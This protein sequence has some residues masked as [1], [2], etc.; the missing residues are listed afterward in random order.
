MPDQQKRGN[1]AAPTPFPGGIAIVGMGRWGHSLHAALTA[2]GIPPLELVVRT[3]KKQAPKAVSFRKARFDAQ[4]LW[5]CVPDAAIA[6]VAADLSE[7]LPLKEKIVVHSSGVY[8]SEILRA[9]KQAGARVASVHPLMTF[10]TLTPVPLVNV[11]FAIESEKSIAAR[12]QKLVTILAGRP[13][14][15]SGAGKPLYHAAA[16][17]ASPLLVGLATAAR[18]MATQAGLS[19]EDSDTLLQPIMLATI[20]NFFS[21]GGPASFSGPFARGDVATVSLHLAALKE[22]PSLQQV[23]QALANFALETLPVKNKQEL[24]HQLGR[25]PILGNESE[26]T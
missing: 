18:A 23:Y 8:S 16:V 2:A 10:P 26:R 25:Q 21:N 3:Q 9:A 7:R 20:R 22:H 17:M 14:L 12:L 4:L 11:P 13:F 1:R 15:L 19:P 5:L 24:K 6:D